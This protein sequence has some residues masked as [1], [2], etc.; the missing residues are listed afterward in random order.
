MLF[1]SASGV[2]A[3]VKKGASEGE[4]S[5]R[6]EP[7]MTVAGRLVARPEAMTASGEAFAAVDGPLI[8]VPALILLVNAALVLRRRWYGGE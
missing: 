6:H 3:D 8:V 2:A 4:M 7:E 5:V 1:R